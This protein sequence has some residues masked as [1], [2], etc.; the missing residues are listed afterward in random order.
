MDPAVLDHERRDR[1][2]ELVKHNDHSLK[3]LSI[4]ERYVTLDRVQDQHPAGYSGVYCPSDPDDLA[5]LGSAFRQ[6]DRVSV[7]SFQDCFYLSYFA[8]STKS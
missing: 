4:A 1:T 2:L 5:K 7:L 3:H 8:A 6:N